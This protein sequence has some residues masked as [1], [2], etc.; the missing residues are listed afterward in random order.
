MEVGDLM[1]RESFNLTDKV[2]NALREAV[3]E[4][5][6]KLTIQDLRDRYA[7]KSTAKKKA[8]TLHKLGYISV[9]KPGIYRV[10]ELPSGM[11]DEEERTKGL[12][13]FS[14]ASEEI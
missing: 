9:V 1:D 7:T 11:K 13:E 6:R 12:D 3:E 4:N 14:P 5:G 8:K 2:E 10:E